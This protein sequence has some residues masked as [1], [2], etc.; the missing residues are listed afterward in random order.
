ARLDVAVLDLDE[1]R[2]DLE[3][4]VEEE[5]PERVVLGE[6]ASDA[7]EPAE[8][9]EVA[10]A[11]GHRFS[12][13]QR[14]PAE[15]VARDDSRGDERAALEVLERRAE[16]ALARTGEDARDEADLLVLEEPHQ[17]PQVAL[18]YAHVRVAHHEHLTAR[19][20]LEAEK[21]SDLRVRGRVGIGEDDLR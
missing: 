12:D 7:S 13:R 16:R 21:L 8:E 11:H 18:G 14:S 2:A 9:G 3:T 17:I 5:A 6:D 15:R 10:L 19:A 4:G 20:C 1:R